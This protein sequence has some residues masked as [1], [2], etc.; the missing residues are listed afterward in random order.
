MFENRRS[1]IPVVD[2]YF[3]VKLTGSIGPPGGLSVHDG[4]RDTSRD[5]PDDRPCNH[6]GRAR[7]RPN[8]GAGKSARRR[9]L[10]F[11]RNALHLL[12]ALALALRLHKESFSFSR[13]RHRD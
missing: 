10:G 1:K 5:R 2:S 8:D 3:F 6:A 9:P 7:T 12:M 13:K 11:V 4:T